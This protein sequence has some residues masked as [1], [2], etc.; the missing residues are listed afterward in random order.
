MVGYLLLFRL[1]VPYTLVRRNPE[2]SLLLL[3]PVFHP[4]AVALAPLVRALRKRAVAATP[5]S[6][7]SSRVTQPVEVP[8]PPVHDEDEGRLV[9]A[10]GAASR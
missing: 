8:P 2:R 6:P 4:Y 7:T 9:D 1:S 5:T 10:R 3:L